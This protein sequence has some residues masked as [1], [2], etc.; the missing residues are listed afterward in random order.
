MAD[1]LPRFHY[2]VRPHGVQVFRVTSGNGNVIPGMPRRLK[3]SW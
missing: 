3:M 2:R 1:E